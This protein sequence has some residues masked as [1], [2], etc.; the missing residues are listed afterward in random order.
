M[1][2]SVLLLFALFFAFIALSQAQCD[3][4]CCD[5]YT[6]IQNSI[7]EPKTLVEKL[8]GNSFASFTIDNIFDVQKLSSMIHY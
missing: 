1:S 2:R 3:C 7:K 5:A 4:S 8:T 6:F